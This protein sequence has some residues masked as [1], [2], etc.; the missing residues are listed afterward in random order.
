MTATRKIR[1]F[2]F[3]KDVFFLSLTCIGG[4]Q[5][6]FLFF[7]R[8]LVNYRKY[9]TEAELLELQAL[10]S[11]LPGPTSTQTLT[12]IG[13]KLGGKNLAYLTLLVW[14][15]PACI[16]MA[17]VAISLN[18]I[19]QGV[20]ER[21]TQFIRPMAV[22]FVIFAATSISVKSID[23]KTSFT[24]MIT[25]IV[26]GYYFRSPY[27]APG[28]ILFSGLIAATKYRRQ[29]KI[30]RSKFSF[31]FSDLISWGMLFLTLVFIGTV[32]Q[33]LPIRLFENFYRNGSLAFGGG[34]ILKP[35]LFNEFVEFKK[36]LSA[37][38]YLSGIAI[39][40]I[41]PGPTFSIASYV[42]ALS[43]HSEGLS[44]QVL[45]AFVASLGIFLPGIFMIFFTIKIW[46]NLKKYRGIRASLEG[47]N[48]ATIGLTFAAGISLFMPMSHSYKDIF[49]VIITLLLLYI[50]KIPSYAI[51][52]FGILAGYF[53]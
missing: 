20:L 26:L 37:D 25:A 27:L 2:I 3:L 28:V 4:P 39:S 44:G 53:L 34:H 32:S 46:E 13:Y 36:Y 33:S 49:T 40:E 42:G 9:L 22:A 52:I 38:Q 29:N 18:F 21:L 19:E 5:S 11:I 12:A 15:S 41:V 31:D 10:C 23:S 6:H 35:L 47:V 51:I 7:I 45:G 8:R 48:A 24:L 50:E 16:I 1:F 17:G 14:I 43:M 30:E